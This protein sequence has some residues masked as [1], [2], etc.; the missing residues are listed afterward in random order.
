MDKT[1]L[2]PALP[3][4]QPLTF[5]LAIP[6]YREISGRSNE[7]R[8]AGVLSF[9]LD[10]K[11]FLA[12]QLGSVAPGIP[13]DQIWIVDKDGTLLFSPTILIWSS[14]IFIKESE[15]AVPVTLLS[16]MWKKCW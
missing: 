16:I 13:L 4:P 9:T 12:A 10:M 15:A 7:A 11:E 2:S 14:E 3:G 1:S 5:I 6:L 8:F